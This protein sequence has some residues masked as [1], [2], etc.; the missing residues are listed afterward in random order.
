MID[1][2]GSPLLGDFGLSRICNTKGFTTK[3]VMGSIR[4]MSPEL[5]RE[6][7][8]TPQSDSSRDD[9]I[10]RTTKASDI[11]AFGMTILEV[12]DRRLVREARMLIVC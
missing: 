4:W 7:T 2:N 1:E 6:W 8:N 5:L 3:N 9:D 12:R 11:W 10:V